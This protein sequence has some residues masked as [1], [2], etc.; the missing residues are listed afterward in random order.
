MTIVISQQF[1]TAGDIVD[2]PQ[3][4]YIILTCSS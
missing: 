4:Y 2:F 3:L 1:N